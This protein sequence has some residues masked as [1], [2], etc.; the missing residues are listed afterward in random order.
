[1]TDD[2]L[3]LQVASLGPDED[4]FNSA[5]RNVVD[6]PVV[7]EYLRETNH[8]LLSFQLLE[9]TRKTR[10]PVVPNRYR[11]EIYDYTNN[12]TIVVVGRLND[13]EIIEVSQSGHQPLPTDEEF[14]AAIMILQQDSDLGPAMREQRLQPYR[15]MPPLIS[16]E[17]PDGRVERTL[18][19]G[20]LATDDRIRH[21]IVGV[22]MSREVVIHEIPDVAMH[23]SD[24]C[25]PPSQGGCSVSGTGTSARVRVTQGSTL[26]WTF[27]VVR[28]SASSGT[29]GS[30]IELQHVNYRGKQVLYRAHVPILNVEYSSDGIEVGCGPTYRDWQNS[31]TCFQAVGVDPVP[32]FRLCSSPAQTILDSGTDA[33]NF[34]GVAIY[35]DGQEVVLVSEL[36][37]GWYRYVSEWRLHTNGTIRPRFGFAATDNSCTCKKHHHHAY[38][39][40]DFDIRTAGNNL[41]EEFND[42]SLSGSSNW[43]KKSFEIRRLRDASRKRKW[44]VSNTTTGEGYELIPGANDGAADSYGVGDVWILRYNGSLPAPAGEVDDGQ[45]FTTDWA[46]SKANLDKFVTGDYIENQDVVLWYAGHFLHDVHA[47]GSHI[48]GPELKPFNW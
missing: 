28:P 5:L 9:G 12:R 20:L 13:Q 17:L 29:N 27:T 25:G 38:W 14:A 40:F 32:G 45:G 35:V 41:V 44:R 2:R 21:R 33:G 37:A 15:P 34:Q 36:Q 31:E 23:S 22:N 16:T 47:G 24:D 46:K 11:A 48:V 30:G 3:E 1:M 43:H 4:T 19:V 7:Q 42:P 18:A 6:H 26:L 10:R 8:R 39:R